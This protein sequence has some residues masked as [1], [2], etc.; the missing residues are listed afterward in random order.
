MRK[1]IVSISAFIKKISLSKNITFIRKFTRYLI[2]NILKDKKKKQ[3]L[4][5]QRK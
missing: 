4:R 2:L 3:E 1:I 5:K